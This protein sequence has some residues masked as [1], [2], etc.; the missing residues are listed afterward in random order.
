MRRASSAA[1]RSSRVSLSS[2]IAADPSSK[3][4]C[5]AAGR[6]AGRRRQV[7][8]ASGLALEVGDLVGLLLGLRVG[9]V[10]LFLLLALLLFGGALALEAGVAREVARGLLGAAAGLVDETH[11]DSLLWGCDRRIP[12][13]ED[14]LNSGPCAQRADRHVLRLAAP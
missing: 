14:A 6:W 7:S 1:A 10:E 12:A 8:G 13:R 3:K 2:A 5:G 4:T 11:I 9:L